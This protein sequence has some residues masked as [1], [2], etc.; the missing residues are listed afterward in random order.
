MLKTWVV[1]ASFIFCFF[2]VFLARAAPQNPDLTDPQLVINLP[3][4]TLELYAGNRLI[5]RYPVAIGKPSTPTPLGNY[6]ITIKEVNPAWYPPDSPGTVVSS[7]PHNPLGYR[8]MGFL[9]TYGVHGTN[10]PDSIGLVVSNGCIRMYEPDVEELYEVVR[11]NT[12]LRIIYERVRVGIDYQNRAYIAVYPDV[13]GWQSVSISD[14]RVKLRP[15]NWNNW[16]DDSA[17]SRMIEAADDKEYVFLQFHHLVVNGK[18]LPDKVQ[19]S[20]DGLLV[21]IQSIAEAVKASITWDEASSQIKV[22]SRFFRGVRKDGSLYAAPESIPVLFG[23]TQQIN[24]SQGALG[25]EIIS[26]TLNGKPVAGDFP[27]RREIPLLPVL[28]I[29]EA[30]GQ[31]AIWDEKTKILIANNKVVPI[32]VIE[33]KPYLAINQVYSYFGAYVYWDEAARIIDLT[34]PFHEPDGD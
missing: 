15:H 11:V 27:L 33:N 34:Y 25:V 19:I 32:Q 28:T 6:Y 23:G 8:W 29:G 30:L 9:P 17:I 22:G 24:S 10:N 5:K 4:R 1:I 31:K 26:L 16:V 21:P 3:S 13:Y 18:L 7:G 20:T 2:P 14:V 12:P